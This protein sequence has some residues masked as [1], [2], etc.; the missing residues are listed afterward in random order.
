MQDGQ[1]K[2][3]GTDTSPI[4]RGVKSGLKKKGSSGKRMAQPT[5]LTVSAHAKEQE[6]TK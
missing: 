1:L 6:K 3:G 2:K 5:T 4:E